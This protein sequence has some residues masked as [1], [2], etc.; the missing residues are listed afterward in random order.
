MKKTEVMRAFLDIAEKLGVVTHA[1]IYD[2]WVAVKIIQEDGTECSLD[3]NI[4]EKKEEKTD[5]N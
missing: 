2:T 1:S 5:G 4:F 3:F